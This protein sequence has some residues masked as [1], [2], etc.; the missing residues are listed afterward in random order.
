MTVPISK[1]T[2]VDA[3]DAASDD[4]VHA[5]AEMVNGSAVALKLSTKRY[6]LAN[7][8]IR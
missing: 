3:L 5:S 4:A 8:F 1:A 7:T 6:L 2:E